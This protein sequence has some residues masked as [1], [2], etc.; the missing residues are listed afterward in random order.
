[1]QKEKTKMNRNKKVEKIINEWKRCVELYKNKKI[2]VEDAKKIYY[3]EREIKLSSKDLKYMYDDYYF[4]NCVGN[5]TLA[6]KFFELKGLN[7]SEY[8]KLPLK[9]ANV[10]AGDK[11]LDVGCGR[12]EIIFQTAN[13]G[14]ISTGLDFSS[15]AIRIAQSVREMHSSEIRN[16]INFVLSDCE[17]ILFPDNT[18]DKVFLLDVVEHLSN[19]EINAIFLEIRRVLKPNGLLIIHT[20][21]NGW[22]KKYGYLITFTISFFLH[23]NIL[24]HPRILELKENLYYILH[25][26]EQSILSLKL[27]LYK[28]GFRSDVWTQKSK[29]GSRNDNII[30]ILYG[31]IFDHELYAIAIPKKQM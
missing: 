18:F 10:K 1:M 21:P 5:K 24:I 9:L 13:L 8:K 25:I 14:A 31:W 27:L 6:D 30:K 22:I 12:G 28:C 2:T 3:M 29:I 7:V 20:S 15:D 19:E 11:V 23:R 26:N 4:R 16:R 17:E